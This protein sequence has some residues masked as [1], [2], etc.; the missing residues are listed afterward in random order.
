VAALEDFAA[1]HGI[2]FV[3]LQKG[4]AGPAEH[5][6]RFAGEE[7][8]VFI[9]KAQVSGRSAVHCLHEARNHRFKDSEIRRF[10]RL[11]REVPRQQCAPQRNKH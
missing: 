10:A 7:G 11:A 4:R 8:A 1:R 3:L 5:L 2:S 9:G 6:R